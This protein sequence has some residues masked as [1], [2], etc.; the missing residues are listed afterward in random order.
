MGCEEDAVAAGEGDVVAAERAESLDVL[1]PGFVASTDSD[2]IEGALGVDRVVED[3]AVD[4]QAERVELL[5]LAL[6]VRLAQLAAAAVADV[7]REAVATFTAV[8]LD[9]NA[10]TE[11]LVV[12]VVEQMDRFR[13]SADVL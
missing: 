9:Q 13:G 5:L 1:V 10:A 3:D 7:A 12:A 8:E 11:V 2:V 6:A 4:D